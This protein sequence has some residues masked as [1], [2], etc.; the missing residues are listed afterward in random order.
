MKD[1]TLLKV[2]NLK[3]NFYSKNNKI[4][5]VR[6]VSFHVNPGDILG[7]VGESGSGKSVLMRSVMQILPENAKI[8]SGEVYFDGKDILKLDSKEAKGIKGKEIAMIFQNPMTA[9]NPLKKIGDH[10]VEV[11]VR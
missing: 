3:A 10:I 4:E 2:N 9:L 11:L 6:G 7:I 8:D 5:A 1:E